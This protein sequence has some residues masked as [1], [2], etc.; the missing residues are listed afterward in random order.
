[1]GSPTLAQAARPGQAPLALAP[2]PARPDIVLSGGWRRTGVSPTRSGPEGSSR[3][4]FL[5]GSFV[6]PPTMPAPRPDER[7]IMNDGPT[8]Y[9]VLARKY[10]PA[11][12][13]ELI[14]QEAM[15]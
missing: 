7:S 5:L 13:A 15:V 2:G 11:T 3:N 14:G 8:A 10:R 9:R 4:E 1:M 6:Q 12:F